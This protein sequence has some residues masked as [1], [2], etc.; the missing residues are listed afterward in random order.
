MDDLEGKGLQQLLS[1][2]RRITGGSTSKLGRT[3][4]VKAANVFYRTAAA[5]K[6]TGSWARASEFA[7]RALESDPNHAGA[8]NALAQIKARPR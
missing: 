1:L 4:G 2:D 5:A 7:A 6:T 3:A 8:K